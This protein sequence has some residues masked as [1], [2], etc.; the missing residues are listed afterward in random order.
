MVAYHLEI[1]D[2]SIIDKV[3]AF[4]QTLPSSAVTLTEEK[5]N[6]FIE[7][8]EHLRRQMDAPTVATHQEAMTMLKNKYLFE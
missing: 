4:F 7:L 5:E 6:F 2:E 3:K 1:N 8:E